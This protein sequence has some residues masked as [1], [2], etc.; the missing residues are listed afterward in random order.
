[1]AGF[2]SG[3]AGRAL[4]VVTL[5]LALAL[6]LVLPGSGQARDEEASE[7]EIAALRARIGV[8]RGRVEGAEREARNLL[9]AIQELDEG[10]EALRGEVEVS[11]QRSEQAVQAHQR[12]EGERTIWTNRLER[13]RMAMARRAVALYKAGGAGPLEVLFA[14]SDLPSLLVRMGN[15]E[16]LLVHDSELIARSV[17]ELAQVRVLEV[18]TREARTLSEAALQRLA[19]RSAAL[20]V[21]RS[22]R[23]KALDRVRR[24]GARE[25]RLVAEMEV[26]AQNL[27]ETLKNLRARRVRFEGEGFAARKGKLPRPVQGQ[28]RRSFGLVVDPDYQTEIFHKGLEIQ[29]PRGDQVRSVA[30]GRVRMAGWFRGY[31][32]LVIVDHGQGY[33]TVSGHLADIFVEVGDSVEPG[34]A[35]GTVGDTG[36]LEG[37]GLYFEV[38]RGSGPLDPADW[39]AK[40]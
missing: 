1:M 18:E 33:F 40:G 25:R 20:G 17:R 26:A 2:H 34:D 35:L 29:A 24:D 12:V 28:V 9:G 37:P 10:L 39:L 14:S 32:K 22:A 8:S 6:A 23:G 4:G 15:L 27:E 7:R 3:S 11:R 13:T 19:R 5:A 30:P 38:R 16:R 36:S 31:G 21:E